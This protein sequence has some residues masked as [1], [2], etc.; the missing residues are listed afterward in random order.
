MLDITQS[1]NQM[2]AYSKL[3]IHPSEHEPTLPCRNLYSRRWGGG[4]GF[5][6]HVQRHGITVS[7]QLVASWDQ[8]L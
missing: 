5:L 6:G 7:R 2:A 4:G 8:T 1:T 3:S